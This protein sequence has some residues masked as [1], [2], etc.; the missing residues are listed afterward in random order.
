LLTLLNTAGYRLPNKEEAY[1]IREQ[2]MLNH[3]RVLTMEDVD[4]STNI[5]CFGTVYYTDKVV[6]DINTNLPLQPWVSN[7]RLVKI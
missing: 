1:A 2:T 6:K 5:T 4:N 3:H 7:L